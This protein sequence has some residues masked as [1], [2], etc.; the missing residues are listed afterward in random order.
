MEIAVGVSRKDTHWQ[1]KSMSWN[2][3][4]DRLRNVTRTPEIYAHYQRMSKTEQAEIKDVGGFVGGTLRG[5]RRKAGEVVSRS[6]LT[7]DADYA[8]GFT[9]L[10]SA[11]YDDRAYVIYSTHSHSAA[12]PRYRL[13]MPLQRPVTPDEYKALAHYIA[14]EIGIDLFDDSTYEPERLMYWPSAAQDAE[15]VCVSS[16]EQPW[17]DPDELF[18]KYPTWR[19][20]A[21]WPESSRA[22]KARIKH[23][24]RQGEPRDK[25]GA[26]GAFCRVYT[27]EEA[28]AEFLPDVYAPCDAPNRYTYVDGSTA[29]GLVVYDDVFAFSHHG[30]DPAGG[31][32]CNAFDLVRIHLYGELDDDAKPGTPVN[33][34]PSYAAMTSFSVND[35]TVK[36]ELATTQRDEIEQDFSDPDAWKKQLQFSDRGSLLKNAHNAS[37]ILQNDSELQ[38][39]FG[40]DT[41]THRNVILKPLPWKHDEHWT[42]EDDADLRLYVERKY[43]FMGDKFLL[44]ATSLAM[45]V[46]AYHPVVD[47]LNSLTWDG[48]KRLDTMLTTFMGAEDTVYTREV[49]RKWMAA[50]VARVRNPGCKFDTMLILVGKQGLGKSQFFAWL[51]RQKRWFSDSVNKFD[52]SKDSMEQLGGKWIIEIGELNVLKKAEVEAIKTFLTKEVDSYRPS[53]GR[54]TRDYPRQ[55]VFAGTSNRDD[56]LQ[57]PTGNR[58]FWPVMVE[59]TSRMW[60]ELTPEMVDQLWAEADAAHKAGEKLYLTGDAAEQA[61]ETQERFTELGGKIGM[62]EEY[63]GCLVPPDWAKMTFDKRLEWKRGDELLTKTAGTMKRETITKIE[64]YVE[65]F[66]GRPEEY[67][68]IDAY[69]MADILTKLGWRQTGELKAVPGCGRQRAFRVTSVSL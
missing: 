20:A 42:D 43:K 48:T 2:D 29:A 14:A 15:Y 25:P 21:T 19:D 58:R 13:V 28:I 54:N 38:G 59:D 44:D 40:Y 23:A 65:C 22:T 41:F 5:P 63:L 9:E 69:E 52:N 18:N 62:A 11:R 67:R 33:R 53:Y 49:A 8:V 35:T 3:L 16:G 12:K 68:K 30:S 50:A 60:A 55:C 46:N 17:F 7:L 45:R 64:L 39:A 36:I 51:A 57:D 31:Q 32:L 27:I 6:L 61:R 34:L 66:N 1:N 24:D 37:L 4:A 47:Y 56:F 10:V 26:V